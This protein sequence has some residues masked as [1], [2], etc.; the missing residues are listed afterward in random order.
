MAILWQKKT[1]TTHYE[2]R[3]AG[4]SLRLYTNGIF[5]SQWNKHAPLGGHVWDLLTLPAFLLSSNIKTKALVLGVGGGAAINTLNHFFDF[6]LIYGVDLDK[7]HLQ[8]ARRWFKCNAENTT[9]IHENALAFVQQTRQKFDLLV[10]D[11]FIENPKAL[12]DAQRAIPADTIWFTKL[13]QRLKNHGLLVVNFASP[14]SLQASLQKIAL[15]DIGFHHVYSLESLRYENAIAV[16]S[17][18]SIDWSVLSIAVEQHIGKR[19]TK[20]ALDNVIIKTLV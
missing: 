7:Y 17:R 19:S 2:V 1:D 6:D 15:N 9:L 20:I 4:A 18:Q 13:S 12:G 8:I 10:E 3:N 16:F 5:H 14:L 11:L